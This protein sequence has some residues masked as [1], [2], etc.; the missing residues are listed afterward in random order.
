MVMKVPT[1]SSKSLH[2]SAGWRLCRTWAQ[3]SIRA[4]IA[5]ELPTIQPDVELGEPGAY[6]GISGRVPSRGQDRIA[7]TGVGSAD[8]G[9]D[10]EWVLQDKPDVTREGTWAQRAGQGVM[11]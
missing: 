9:G 4:S 1:C 10:L 11:P 8:I 6:T 3:E 7:D 2:F 5:A